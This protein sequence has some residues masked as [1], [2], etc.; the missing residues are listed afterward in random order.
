MMVNWGRSS[1][2][3][4]GMVLAIPIATSRA[5][6]VAR[7]VW[8][9]LAARGKGTLATAKKRRTPCPKDLASLTSLAASLLGL[10]SKELVPVAG[11]R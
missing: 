7:S 2:V 3:Y 5:A 4:L 6:P 8:T 11:T 9:G 10:H 1:T